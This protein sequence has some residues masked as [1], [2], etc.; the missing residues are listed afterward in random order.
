MFVSPPSLSLENV[1][2]LKQNQ[3]CLG[4]EHRRYESPMLSAG[5]CWVNGAGPFFPPQELHNGRHKDQRLRPRQ[6]RQKTLHCI[7]A[8]VCAG[9]Y[10]QISLSGKTITTKGHS[11]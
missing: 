9:Q 2:K 3:K 6:G 4:N 10:D 11:L 5:K 1:S 8:G 7:L